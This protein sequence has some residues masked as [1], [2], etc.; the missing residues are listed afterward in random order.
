M[1]PSTK[2]VINICSVV[3]NVILITVL[4]VMLLGNNESSTKHKRSKDKDDKTSY[5]GRELSENQDDNTTPII[6]A[7]LESER[8]KLPQTI[9]KMGVKDIQ[10]I[11]IVIDDHDNEQP[12]SGYLN[13]TWDYN[14]T[15][16]KNGTKTIEARND[17]V[18]VNI[19]NITNDKHG[20]NWTTAWQ[21]ALLSLNLSGEFGV[22]EL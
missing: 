3:L 13:T 10:I 7:I 1:N 11:G 18:R 17:Y 15:V 12:Y 8:S 2:K 20:I 19:V 16:W 5:L 21:S 22:E 9:N 14:K 4:G 6:E